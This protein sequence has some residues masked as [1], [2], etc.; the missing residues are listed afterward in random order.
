MRY[1]T[2]LFLVATIALAAACASGETRSKSA[3]ASGFR[4]DLISREQ[5]IESHQT[6]AYDVVR[7][8]RPG[9]LRK[10][11][12]Q[13]INFDGDI[14]VYVDVNRLGG[15]ES[16]RQIS[17]E[18]VSYIQFID[19]PTATQRWGLDHGHGVILVSTRP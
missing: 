3:V 13:S 10:R 4:F 5:V 19:G 6:N 7:A 2:Q 14:V 1:P 17:A 11:G 18:S 8:L 16:L 9:W 12:A 15:P